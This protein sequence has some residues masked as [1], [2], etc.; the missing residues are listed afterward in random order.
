MFML[1]Y[2]NR[3]T[4]MQAKFIWNG[5]WCYNFKMKGR[6]R[7]GI[8]AKQWM[9]CSMIRYGLSSFQVKD[10]KLKRFLAKNRYPQTKLLYFG[11]WNICESST[12]KILYPSLETRQPVLQLSAKSFETMRYLTPNNALVYQTFNLNY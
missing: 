5:K 6:L 1:C 3:R 8:F 7:K 11:N 2:F 12:P 10:T 4:I 9:L